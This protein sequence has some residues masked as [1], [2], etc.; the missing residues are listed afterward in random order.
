MT[1]CYWLYFRTAEGTLS[2]ALFDPILNTLSVEVMFGVAT[3]LCDHVGG[4]ILTEANC[5]SSIV[6]EFVRVVLNFL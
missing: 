6:F 1:L 2:L 3:E 4:L 5:T